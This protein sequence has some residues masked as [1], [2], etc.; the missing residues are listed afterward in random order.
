MDWEDGGSNVGSRRSTANRGRDHV[1]E[2]LFP[3]LALFD[4]PTLH[5][6]FQ[7]FASTLIV[8]IEMIQLLAFTLNTRFGFTL[9]V[10]QELA[11]LVYSAHIP[12]WDST[13]ADVGYD[14]YLM[15]YGVVVVLVLVM[16]LFLA[17]GYHDFFEVS[18]TSIIT[19]IAVPAVHLVCGILAVPFF[20]TLAANMFCHDKHLWAF[21]GEQCWQLKSTLL[22]VVSLVFGTCLLLLS[23]LGA[24]VL[25]QDNLCSTHS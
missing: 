16:S 6:P 24:T 3:M 5:T 15:W 20:H 9:P 1:S 2:R 10:A 25:F 18:R 8:A 22:F 23:L 7:F 17:G 14:A 12:I 19:A 4:S 11:S 21:P 13:F